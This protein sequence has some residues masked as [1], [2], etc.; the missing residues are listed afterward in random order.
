MSKPDPIRDN[1]AAI[2]VSFAATGDTSHIDPERAIIAAITANEFPESKSI[3][4]LIVALLMRHC[5]LF[6]VERL[7][8]ESTA[9]TPHQLATLGGIAKKVFLKAKD[10]RWLGLIKGCEKRLGEKNKP[11]WP[12]LEEDGFH[13]KRSGLDPDFLH[14][15][16]QI[17]TLE[18]ADSKKIRPVEFLIESNA[19]F[20][21]R[22][23]FGVN[24][25][26]DSITILSL[27]KVENA[28]RLKKL[29]GCSTDCAY[30]NWRDLEHARGKS[31]RI[32]LLK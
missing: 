32:N 12:P 27:E 20:K 23:I 14:F 2:G 31:I 28:N 29:L 4:R 10:Q 7:K 19:W 24:M 22:Q 25:R 8:T 21:H 1:L 5:S 6:H 13:I 30:R 17:P 15:G 18:P 16:I 3:V 9:L 11:K 26:A